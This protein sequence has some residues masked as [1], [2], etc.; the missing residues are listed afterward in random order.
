M[1]SASF[2]QSKRSLNRLILFD[3]EKLSRSDYWS[4]ERFVHQSLLERLFA[5]PISRSGTAPPEKTTGM[6]Q[7]HFRGTSPG[8][9]Q[10]TRR[11]H[12]DRPPMDGPI[13][14]DGHHGTRTALGSAGRRCLCERLTST[15]IWTSSIRTEYRPIADRASLSSLSSR[16]RPGARLRVA[17]DHRCIPRTLCSSMQAPRTHR[18]RRRV[19][20]CRRRA[21]GSS[22]PRART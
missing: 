16:T 13:T 7:A 14:L 12:G 5:P 8:S 15:W 9:E 4:Q 6:N 2:G 3:I 10:Q 22:R 21:G 1:R 18:L 17:R 20:R 19:R 11:D